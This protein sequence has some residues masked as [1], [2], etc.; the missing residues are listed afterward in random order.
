MGTQAAGQEPCDEDCDQ[1]ASGAACR[2]ENPFKGEH[3][4][5]WHVAFSGHMR[6]CGTSQAVA[7]STITGMACPLTDPQAHTRFNKLPALATVLTTLPVPDGQ[8]CG[9]ALTWPP[10]P[11]SAFT[12]DACA[13]TSYTGFAVFS[14]S[15]ICSCPPKLP[16]A[17]LRSTTLDAPKVP[18]LKLLGFCTMMGIGWKGFTLGEDGH[19]QQQQPRPEGFAAGS[20]S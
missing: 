14:R 3:P 18:H 9:N 6:S 13:C 7:A 20:M 17:S 5:K 15:H 2:W 4:P 12:I 8:R 16:V 10:H 11:S 1:R 19:C